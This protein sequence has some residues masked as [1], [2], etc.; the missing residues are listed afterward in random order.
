LTLK[1]NPTV[2]KA[3]GGI[4]ENLVWKKS[5]LEEIQLW[6]EENYSSA[7]FVHDSVILINSIILT[8]LLQF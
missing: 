2:Q 6:I 4:A 8:I 1:D 5:K 7:G 3:L